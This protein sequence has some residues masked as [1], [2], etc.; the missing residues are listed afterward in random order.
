[1]IT[2]LFAVQFQTVLLRSTLM[3]LPHTTEI[4]TPMSNTNAH[5]AM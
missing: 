1:M 3:R 4:G 5:N 2:T